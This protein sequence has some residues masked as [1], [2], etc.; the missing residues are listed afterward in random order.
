MKVRKIA[1]PE[2]YG[3]KVEIASGLYGDQFQAMT[4]VRGHLAWQIR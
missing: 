4:G 3:V 2:P 1:S